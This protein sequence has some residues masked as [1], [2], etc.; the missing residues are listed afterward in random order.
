MEASQ[1][2]Q[3]FAEER[4][5]HDLHKIELEHLTTEYTHVLALL[6]RKSINPK[7]SPNSPHSSRSRR[8]SSRRSKKEKKV[9]VKRQRSS[10]ADISMKVESEKEIESSNNLL[11]SKGREESKKSIY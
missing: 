2:A 10:F 4:H 11:I 3:L 5:L 7:E 1:T 6:N 9:P 8:G